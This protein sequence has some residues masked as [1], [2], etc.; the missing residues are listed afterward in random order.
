MTEEC[1]SCT[2]DDKNPMELNM[3]FEDV[4]NKWDLSVNEFIAAAG[5]FALTYD[6]ALNSLSLC[7]D[8][9][10][11]T[12]EIDEY[13][14]LKDEVWAEAN[15]DIDG[16]LCIACIEKRIGRQLTAADFPS[17]VPLNT[18]VRLGDWKGS[19]QLLEAM[20]RGSTNEANSNLRKP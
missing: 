14:T 4:L 9:K 5:E 11:D 10:R 6:R 1:H 18:A 13:Y 17:D 16:M 15:P 19:P 3:D 8:C 2:S 20:N 7:L 12:S